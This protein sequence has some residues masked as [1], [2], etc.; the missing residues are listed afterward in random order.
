MNCPAAMGHKGGH[1]REPEANTAVRSTE[2]A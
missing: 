1:F 2:V